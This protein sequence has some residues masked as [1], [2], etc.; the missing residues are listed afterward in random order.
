MGFFEGGN[1]N[2]VLAP[3][4]RSPSK[5]EASSGVPAGSPHRAE[6]LAVRRSADSELAFLFP[7]LALSRTEARE[8]ASGR[9]LGRSL[10]SA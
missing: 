2:R 1:Q 6:A 10:G 9:I 5:A 7:A 3:R 8:V 4:L